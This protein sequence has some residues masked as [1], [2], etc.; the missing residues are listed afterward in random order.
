MKKI[1][2]PILLIILG[3]TFLLPQETPQDSPKDPF[4]ET[5]DEVIT[6]TTPKSAVG[7]RISSFGILSSIADRFAIEH[8]KISG[9]SYSFEVRAFGSKGLK[10]PATWVFSME[11]SSLSGS[12]TFQ[13]SENKRKYENA[14]GEA[15]QISMCG[16][17]LI[18]F[19][20]R[21]PVHPYI[22]FGLGLGRISYWFEGVYEDDIGTPMKET[23]RG[24]MIVPV[25]HLPIGIV[26]NIS[27][28]VEIRLEGGFKNGFYIGLAASYYF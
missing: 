19:F 21:L 8:P 7:M 1:I 24:N 2:I 6:P 15:Y 18:N 3:S 26:G 10:S 16:T 11:Y 12:G 5:E 27:D 25:A 23:E 13:E 14:Y 17:V 9:T 4:E 28:T 20:P 22:G